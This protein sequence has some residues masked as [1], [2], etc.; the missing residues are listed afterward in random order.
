MKY[1]VVLAQARKVGLVLEVRSVR[2]I[3]TNTGPTYTMTQSARRTGFITPQA[4]TTFGPPPSPVQNYSRPSSSASF[5]PLRPS[6][7]VAELLSP[8]S[9]LSGNLPT[10]SSLAPS[11]R[12]RLPELYRSHWFPRPKTSR[13]AMNLSPYRHLIRVLN[14]SHH[15]PQDLYL[16]SRCAYR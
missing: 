5:Y 10:G 11:D 8:R 3:I 4:T 2:L 15:Y 7:A 1:T 14:S 12:P 9:P 13:F 6:S 16:S